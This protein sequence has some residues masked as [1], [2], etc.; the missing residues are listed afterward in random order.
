VRSLAEL[1]WFLSAGTAA[2]LFARGVVA[3]RLANNPVAGAATRLVAT[4]GAAALAPALIAFMNIVFACALAPRRPACSAAVLPN[5]LLVLFSMLLPAAR[6]SDK[7]H[8]VSAGCAAAPQ[9]AQLQETDTVIKCHAR[10][11]PVVACTT[12]HGFP[13][14]AWPLSLSAR[15][16]GHVVAGETGA[17]SGPVRARRRFGGQFAFVELITS[18]RAPR[19]FPAA[20]GVATPLMAALY[21]LLG[22]VGYW[23]QGAGVPELV[24][25]G[26]GDGPVARAAAAAILLQARPGAAGARLRGSAARAAGARPGAGQA[27]VAP[28]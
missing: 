21:L 2:Q 27:A 15:T 12:D 9:V 16:A 23:S 11:A 8:A 10:P 3:W 22:A 13:W 7:H 24:I 25:F 14:H 19:G 28:G 5:G 26:L 17:M 6:H 4:G 20:V 18:M 1:G